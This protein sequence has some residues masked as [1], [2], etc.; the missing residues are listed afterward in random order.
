V[1]HTKVRVAGV[2]AQPQNH[3]LRYVDRR[4]YVVHRKTY[5]GGSTR[6]VPELELRHIHPTAAAFSPDRVVLALQAEAS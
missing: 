5:G 6:A 4:S 1:D 3:V 2:V